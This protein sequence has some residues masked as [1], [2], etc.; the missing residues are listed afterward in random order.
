MLP[1]ATELRRWQDEEKI[2]KGQMWEMRRYDIVWL[3]ERSPF[4]D[5]NASAKRLLKKKKKKEEA[6]CEVQFREFIFIRIT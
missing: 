4:T 3:P 5:V 2:T 6:R 1:K